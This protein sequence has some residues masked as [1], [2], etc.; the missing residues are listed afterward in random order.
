M[1]ISVNS[2]VSN[3][4]DWVGILSSGAC[5]IHCSLLPLT[6][7]IAPAFTTYFENEWVHFLLILLIVPVAGISF[8]KTQRIHGR[9]LPV[10]LALL[11]LALLVGAFGLE[12][13]IGFSVEGLELG[14]TILA[15]I[16]L[17]MGHFLNIKYLKPG[18]AL[19]Y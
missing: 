10:K 6:S 3:K 15:S 5:A 8:Y 16:L 19:N 12:H 14:L 17:M 1:N 13:T 4:L 18:S 9:V 11:G 7:Y 2:E